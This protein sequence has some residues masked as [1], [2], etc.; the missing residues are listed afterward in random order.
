MRFTCCTRCVISHLLLL[1]HSLAIFPMFIAQMTCQTFLYAFQALHGGEQFYTHLFFNYRNI[2]YTKLPTSQPERKI[3]VIRKEA[4]W[5][6]WSDV[7]HMLGHQGDVVIPD[8]SKSDVRNKTGLKLEVNGV[9]TEEGRTK[10]CNAL[11]LEYIAYFQI[12]LRAE[13]VNAKE[14]EEARSVALRNCPRLEIL[15]LL[16]L[17]SF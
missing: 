1:N 7:N 6:D 10:L 9:L 12:L 15:S 16:T 14:L 5:R 17:W 2:L 11:E 13:N 3:Y 4:F 8:M